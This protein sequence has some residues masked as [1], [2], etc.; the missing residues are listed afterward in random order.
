MEMRKLLVCIVRSL[1]K[2]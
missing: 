2:K 1:H